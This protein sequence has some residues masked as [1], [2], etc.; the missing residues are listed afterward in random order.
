MVGTNRI[1]WP[2]YIQ[3]RNI[4][5]SKKIETIKDW[6]R[7]ANVTEVRSFFGLAGYYQRF[8]EGF[9]RIVALLTQLIRKSEKFVWGRK[10]REE[11][12][13]IKN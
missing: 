1:S 5:G 7:P 12:S 2:Y 4:G 11:F 10:S 6:P 8:V 3:R 9:S 13:R